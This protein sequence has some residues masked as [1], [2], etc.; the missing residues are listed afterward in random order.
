MKNVIDMVHMKTGIE[1]DT[2]A[3]VITEVMIT[4]KES[5]LEGN[6]VYWPGLCKFEWKKTAKGRKP[7]VVQEDKI[8]KGKG[9]ISAKGFEDITLEKKETAEVVEE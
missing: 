7:K 6:E 3:Q 2:V 5:L 9:Q 4:T 8:E 1:R